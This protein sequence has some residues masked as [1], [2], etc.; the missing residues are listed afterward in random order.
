M[1]NMKIKFT[2]LALTLLISINSMAQFSID[3]EFR[4]RTEF[5]NGYGNIIA[6]G[7][8][9]GFGV[10]TRTRLN[11]GY[12]TDAYKF[13]LS[14]QDVL[15]WGENR[16][17]LP[18][19]ANDSFSIFQAWADIALGSGWSTKLGRQT[20]IYDDQR[21][22]GAVGWAQQARNHDAAIIKYKK[23]K[24]M[25]DIGLAFSQ[26]GSGVAGFSSVGNT[27]NT[28]GFFTY[29]TM[30]YGYTKKSWSN[31]SGSLLFLANGF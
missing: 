21:I 22:F 5:R 20:I 23:D 26:D 27:Y 6:D 12:K 29:K 2:L 13:Y 17:L 8:E 30:F 15:T 18:Q 7:A 3:G 28:S 9:P 14:F 31:F 10:S 11:F 19:D 25:F 24:F 4:P 1:K 16:Q